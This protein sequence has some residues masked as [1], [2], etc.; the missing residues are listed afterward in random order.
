MILCRLQRIICLLPVQVRA[1]CRR[2]QPKVQR[3]MFSHGLLH[4]TTK[5]VIRNLN[6][7]TN[8]HTSFK[9]NK[10]RRFESCPRW[11]S[12]SRELCS[13]NTTL[14]LLRTTTTTTKYLLLPKL[15]F[16]PRFQL[17]ARPARQTMVPKRSTGV[18][19]PGRSPLAAHRK[20]YD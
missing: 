8:G 12:R 14:P 15:S 5:T 18:G 11:D 9:C 17:R 13:S 16:S 4:I 6:I 20:C 7:Q 2:V 19:D 3:H 10:V 1:R